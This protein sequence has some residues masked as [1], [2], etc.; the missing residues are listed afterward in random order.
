[1]ILVSL[2]HYSYLK[3]T[4]E[5]HHEDPGIYQRDAVV[6]QIDDTDYVFV[7]YTGVWREREMP[8]GGEMLAA[9]PRRDCGR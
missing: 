2:K 9:N 4:Q 6:Y 1:M 5:G 3:C 8:R 7:V